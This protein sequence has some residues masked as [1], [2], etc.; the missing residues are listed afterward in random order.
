MNGWFG[1]EPNYHIII[2]E[3]ESSARRLICVY[4]V[5]STLKWN[6]VKSFEIAD[7]S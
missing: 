7:K 6:A 5:R 1:R 4:D 3:V 2:Q